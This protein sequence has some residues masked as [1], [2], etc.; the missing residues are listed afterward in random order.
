MSDLRDFIHGEAELGSESDDED[1]DD[2][3]GE[4]RTKQNGV[5]RNFEDSSEEDEDDDEEEAEKVRGT[6][7]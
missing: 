3:V 5:R 4:T 1:F 6:K 2:E 7:T